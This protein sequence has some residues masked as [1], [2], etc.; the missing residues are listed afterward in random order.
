MAKLLVKHSST[1]FVDLKGNH[2]HMAKLLVKHSS[3][4]FVDLS[5]LT[6]KHNHKQTQAHSSQ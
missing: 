1:D 6:G 5:H 2:N 4:D 3:T